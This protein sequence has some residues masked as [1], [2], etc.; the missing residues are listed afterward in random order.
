M[1]FGI[2]VCGDREDFLA[3]VS[4][5]FSSACLPREFT[6]PRTARTFFFISIMRNAFALLILTLSAYLYCRHRV[7]RDGKYPIKI[8]KKVPS[9]YQH[10]R[11]T[12]V[13]KDLLAALAPEIPV[14]TI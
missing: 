11:A 8:L 14:A 2:S 6:A 4:F 13:D 9:G 7:S 3:M 5:N 10:I 1:P 12:V